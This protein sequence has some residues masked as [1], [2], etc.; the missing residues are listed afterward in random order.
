M[1]E[2]ELRQWAIEQ[3]VAAGAEAYEVT[4]YALDYI[5]FVFPP[6][7]SQAANPI[8]PEARAA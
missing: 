7:E 5:A 3:A 4:R 2:Y 1:S 6:P 8:A